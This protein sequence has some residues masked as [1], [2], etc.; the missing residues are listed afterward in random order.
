VL[1]FRA[2]TGAGDAQA[3]RALAAVRGDLALAVSRHLDVHARAPA[4]SPADPRPR[5]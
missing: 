4:D 3:R 5:G 2:V 1:E